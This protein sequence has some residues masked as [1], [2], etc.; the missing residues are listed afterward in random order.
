MCG[1]E[2]E[3]P[4]FANETYP[5]ARKQY[6][7]CECG[8]DIDKGEKHQCVTGLWDE[9][10][11]HRTC[12]ICSDIRAVASSELDYNISFECLYET[13]GSEFE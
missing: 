9:F 1:D 6:E 13:I 12:L 8:S 3:T 4:V 10:E 2:G 5:K 11:T 7:C